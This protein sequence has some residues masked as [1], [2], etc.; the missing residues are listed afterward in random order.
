MTPLIRADNLVVNR[1]ERR[2]LAG[3]D[4]CC[5]GGEFVALL[6]L[7]GAGKSTLLETLAG[8]L[9]GYGG[10]CL[11]QGSELREYSRRQL[12]QRLSFLPQWQT[13]ATGFTVRQIVSMGRYPHSSGWAESPDDRRAIEE[14]MDWCHCSPLAARRFQTLSGGERQR[15]LLAAAVAQRA[16]ILVL[17]EPSAHADPPLQASLF[18]LLRERSEQGCLCIAA[19]HDLNLAVAFATR[20]V[21]LHE[22]AIAYDGG[23][24]GFL[25]SDAF[26]NVFGPQITVRQ[27]AAGQRFAAYARRG[28]A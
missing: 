5:N 18:A 25:A 26:G 4:F 17:D 2:V 11:L 15:A 7:N 9:R 6:G 3:V 8:V 16:S 12:S 24:D 20:V 10:S 13:P 27:D 21:L 28:P 22:G 19:V 23:V 14:A 1:G